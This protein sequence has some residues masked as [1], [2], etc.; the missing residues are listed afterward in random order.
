MR[1]LTYSY[2]IHPLYNSDAVTQSSKRAL[3]IARYSHHL[4]LEKLIK[5]VKNLLKPRGN[6]IFCYDAKQIDRV[7]HYMVDSGINPEVLRFVHSKIDRNSKLVMIK[8]RVGSKSM[9]E[10][11]PPLIVFDGDGYSKEA[12]EAFKNAST[13]TIKGDF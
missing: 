12:K 6:F 13:D 5:R 7:L 9:V 3:N 11:R 10:V 8:G 4:P 2:Q 1:S